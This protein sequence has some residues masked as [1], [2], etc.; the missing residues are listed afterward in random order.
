MSFKASISTE[1]S[2]RKRLVRLDKGMVMRGFCAMGEAAA[3]RGRTAVIVVREKCMLSRLAELNGRPSS[4]E[5]ND[6][7][8]RA[9]K[10]LKMDRKKD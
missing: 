4:Y 9:S 7:V 8:K 1:P 3:R 10:L 2:T 5:K 6:E